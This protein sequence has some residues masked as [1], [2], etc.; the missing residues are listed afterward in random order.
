MAAAIGRLAIAAL[1]RSASSRSRAILRWLKPSRGPK[2]MAR[3]GSDR[4][5]QEK[6]RDRTAGGAKAHV[7]GRR[8]RGAAKARFPGRP[9]QPHAVGAARIAKVCFL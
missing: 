7:A 3:E 6:P 1:C 4:A 5:G 2:G 8:H 9:T